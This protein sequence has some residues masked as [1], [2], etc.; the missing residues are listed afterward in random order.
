MQFLRLYLISLLIFLIL[1]F[2][3]LSMLAKS[4]Y[5]KELG[6]Y[7]LDSFKLL[8]AIIF[9]LIFI[10]GLNIFVISNSVSNSDPWLAIGLGAFFGFVTYATYDLTNLATLR[11]WTN[12]ITIV[13]L[14]WGTVISSITSFIT[15][16][17]HTKIWG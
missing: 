16:F 12:T 10:L 1:D 14:V 15:Y 8:P 4:F 7:L 2:F 9:Y 11:F 17:I 6:P 5:Q 3:W 13:D